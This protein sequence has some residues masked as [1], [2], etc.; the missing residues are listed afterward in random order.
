MKFE[1]YKSF[2][3]KNL[4]YRTTQE[5]AQDSARTTQEMAQD[6]ALPPFTLTIELTFGS[7]APEYVV[8]PMV[9][10]LPE[11]TE[12]QKSVL[13]MLRRYTDDCDQ[14]EFFF[15][16]G[17]VD[18]LNADNSKDEVAIPSHAQFE[19]SEFHFVECCF[20][21]NGCWM[22][23]GFVAESRKSGYH[24]NCERREYKEEWGSYFSFLM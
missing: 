9:E 1:L 5:M 24:Y 19:I 20:C 13:E 2:I 6:S 23:N 12:I 7:F 15:V 11:A 18:D 10:A 14:D 22:A 8:I 3:Y 17:I 4:I 21:E 16:F